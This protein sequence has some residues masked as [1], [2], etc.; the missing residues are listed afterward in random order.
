MS[1]WEVK[2]P[3]DYS[4][5]GDDIDSASQKIIATF[6][7]VYDKLNRLRTFDADAS[8]SVGDASPYSIKIDTSVTPPAILMRNGT[9]SGYVQI[10]SVSENMGITAD[11]VGG[12]TGEG[13]GKI[14]LG[15][16]A[17]LPA[18]ATTYDLYFAYDTARLY[19]YRTGAWRV[20]LS[21]KFDDLLG[22]EDKVIMRNE[23]AESGPNKIPRLNSVGQGE[24]SITGSAAKI[25]DK[26]L[27]LPELRDNCVLVFNEARDRWEIAD[28]DEITNAD[29]STTGEPDKIVKTD[30]K[31]KAHVDITG[32]AA[33]VGNKTIDA[34][35]WQ[36]GD[37][38]VYD[39][40]TG[41]LKN[42]Q[43]P[44]LNASG[45]LDTNITGSAAKWAGANKRVVD[46]QDGQVLA[47]SVS[48]NAFVNV[49]QSGI[50]NARNLVLRQND[51]VVAEYNGSERTVVDIPAIVVS[52]DEPARADI[53][54]KPLEEGE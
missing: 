48:E 24:F 27:F 21:L 23:V 25:G 36:T 5:T 4:A 41:T 12:I 46:I 45:S 10:G 6:I 33:K 54:I 22:V 49:N 51:A 50:G 19:I 7:D 42:K 47:W 43:I 39:S 40:D 35:N 16:E 3:L 1:D 28:R 15:A 20:F 53:W 11:D 38:L 14:S 34:S 29:V 30:S 9:N 26:N 37:A 52:A 32:D 2:Q 17:N 8:H 31:G 44:V 18:N 13:V